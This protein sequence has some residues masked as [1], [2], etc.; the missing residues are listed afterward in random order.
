MRL[1]R[2]SSEPCPGAGGRGRDAVDTVV[3]LA[4]ESRGVVIPVSGRKGGVWS[5]YCRAGECGLAWQKFQL[6]AS[7]SPETCRAQV[8]YARYQAPLEL[9]AHWLLAALGRQE[10]FVHFAEGE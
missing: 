5:R 10:G 7:A 1:S 9:S 8:S 3:G 4:L 2:Q 6:R